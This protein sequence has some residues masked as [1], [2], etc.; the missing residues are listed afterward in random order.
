MPLVSVGQI[1]VLH[2]LWFLFCYHVPKEIF[3]HYLAHAYKGL[4]EHNFFDLL[5][6]LLVLIFIFVFFSIF[7]KGDWIERF[8]LR[9]QGE[10][11]IDQIQSKSLRSWRL[12]DSLSPF[13]VPI[14]FVL[15]ELSSIA[16]V[17]RA[18]SSGLSDSVKRDGLRLFERCLNIFR[19]EEVLKF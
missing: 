5:L 15:N 6:K 14:G 17:E 2:V 3:P 1:H 9:G 4:L 16:V 13:S 12:N 8:R 18:I 10:V 19:R 11:I 7:Q